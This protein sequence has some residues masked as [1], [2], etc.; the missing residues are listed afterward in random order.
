[1][2]FHRGAPDSCPGVRLT[3]T[4]SDELVDGSAGVSVEVGTKSKA[5]SVDVFDGTLA[6]TFNGETGGL[7]KG[8]CDEELAAV[9]AEE[10]EGT[11]E[12]ESE[13]I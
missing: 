11:G 8:V 13:S 7:S 1:M 9:S 4:G 6:K 5:S 2:L 12:G 10:L 3:G